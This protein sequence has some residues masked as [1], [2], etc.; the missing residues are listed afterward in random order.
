MDHLEVHDGLHAW[1]MALTMTVHGPSMDH[2]PRT[3][4]HGPGPPWTMHGPWSIRTMVHDHGLY[5]P[6]S[7]RTMD[8]TMVLRPWSVDGP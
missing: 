1:T 3:M 2:R 5:G 8:C 7:L 4:V 6:Y